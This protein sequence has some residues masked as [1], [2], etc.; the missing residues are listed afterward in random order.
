MDEAYRFELPLHEYEDKAT[1]T[2]GTSTGGEQ[3]YLQWGEF[4]FEV[5]GESVTL[6][7]TRVILKTIDCG[8]RF[9]TR[10]VVRKPIVLADILI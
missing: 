6:R 9:G 7:H 8:S 2:V 4:R 1:I 10:P 5:D 3:D